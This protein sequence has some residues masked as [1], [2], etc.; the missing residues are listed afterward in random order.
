MD[1]ETVK[2][3][4]DGRK[5][6]M[7]PATLQTR[8][9]SIEGSEWRSQP[10]TDNYFTRSYTLFNENPKARS[11]LLHYNLSWKCL[12]PQT[13]HAA[14]IVVGCPSK[15]YGKTRVLMTTSSSCH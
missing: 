7:K 13:I 9:K 15:L 6:N 11:K 8:L 10:W 12:G 1:G 2:Q 3:T 14:A 4:K 5:S